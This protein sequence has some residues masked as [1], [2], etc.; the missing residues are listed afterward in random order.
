MKRLRLLEVVDVGLIV[1]GKQILHDVRLEVGE[2]EI[3][4]ILGGNGT[5]KSTLATALMG[6]SGHEP[7]A[8]RIL[9]RGEDITRL[10]ITERARRGI[11]LAWQ[12]PARF[13][14]LTVAEY[15]N[16]GQQSAGNGF[17][18]PASSRAASSA[19]P[20]SAPGPT[21]RSHRPPPTVALQMGN[22]PSQVQVAGSSLIVD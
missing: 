15:L 5:G 6:L 13:E 2:G 9:F 10:P 3:H 4:S 11:T 8:G 12:E 18:S 22:T 7:S 1:G 19:P 17:L 14:G 16:I 20:P 21:P